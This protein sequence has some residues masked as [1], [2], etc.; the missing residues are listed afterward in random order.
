MD[1]V[2]GAD[3]GGGPGEFHGVVPAVHADGHAPLFALL[4]L[5]GDDIGKALGGPA[6]HM[7][8]HVVQACVHGAP[9]S[10]GAEFQGP[11]KPGLDLLGVIFDGLQLGFFRLAQ[12]G[13]G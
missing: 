13:A 5:G 11:V 1:A 6:D 4:A 10:G 7:D 8:I 9:E 3:L 2:G 12:G